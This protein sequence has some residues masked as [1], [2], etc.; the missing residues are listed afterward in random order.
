LS[1]DREPVQRERRAIDGL[2]WTTPDEP[3]PPEQVG[4]PRPDPGK[5]SS[6]P[7]G[8]RGIVGLALL[9]GTAGGVVAAL[10]VGIF[11]DGD[12]APPWNR[13]GDGGRQTFTVEQTSAVTEAAATARPGV[14]RIESTRRTANGVVQDVGSGVVIDKDGHILTNAHVVLDTDTLTVFL[15]DG[16]ERKAILIGHDY[17]FTDLAV[18]QIGPG[19]LQPIKIGDSSTLALGE[20]VVAIGNPLSEFEGSVSV[21]VVSGLNRSRTF[22]GVTQPDL[23][24]TDAAVNQ[25]NSGGALVNLRGEFVGMPTS[26]VRES[27]TGQPVEGIAFALPSARVVAIARGI[28]EANGSYPRPTLAAEHLDL[29]PDVLARAPRLAVD[30][31]ALI[32]QVI[33]GGAADGAG[34]RAGDVITEV[35]GEPVDRRNLL[36]NVL[37]RFESGDTVR[38][39]LNRDGRIIEVEVRLGKRG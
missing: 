5:V 8:N 9:A 17:P 38:V 27:R 34:I 35:A 25:G 13:D 22:D 16:S 26:V 23:I 29:T 28:I 1:S 4:Q 36:L 6:S 21:G 15:A 11:P 7:R 30:E 3:K 2:N 19:G 18:L 14:V 12:D 39:V 31:G 32:T 10:L 33:P 20:T 24:Q 37:M